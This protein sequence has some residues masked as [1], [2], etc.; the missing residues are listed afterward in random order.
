MLHSTLSRIRLSPSKSETQTSFFTNHEAEADVSIIHAPV[1]SDFIVYLTRRTK[2]YQ[3][4]VTFLFLFLVA[5]EIIS[6]FIPSHTK[7][8]E[9]DSQTNKAIQLLGYILL[10]LSPRVNSPSFSP[11]ILTLF[12]LMVISLFLLLICYLLFQRN[13]S[14]PLVLCVTYRYLLIILVTL[15]FPLIIAFCSKHLGNAFIDAQFNY[16]GYSTIFII[17]FFVFSLI[18]MTASLIFFHYTISLSDS[19]FKIFKPIAI[20]RLY[21]LL[22]IKTLVI[23][24]AHSTEIWISLPP[25]LVFIIS[26]INFLCEATQSNW[27]IQSQQ[28]RILTALFSSVLTSAFIFIDTLLLDEDKLHPK[29]IL[30]TSILFLIFSKFAI[31]KI[32]KIDVIK[33]MKRLDS[34]TY[35]DN[36]KHSISVFKDICIG[37]K[38]GHLNVI[39]T[40]HAEEIFERFHNVDLYFLFTR[41]IFTHPKSQISLR[42]IAD[43]IEPGPRFNPILNHI[44]HLILREIGPDNQELHDIFSN[45]IISLHRK[46]K[47]LIVSVR[48]VYD[49]ILNKL[50]RNLPKATGTFQYRYHK[51]TKHLLKFVQ[52]YPGSPDAEYFIKLFTTLFP[53][54]NEAHEIE[55]WQNY[56]PNYIH[57]DITLFPSHLPILLQNKCDFKNYNRVYSN[58][59]KIIPENLFSFETFYKKRMKQIGYMKGP[60]QYIIHKP[61]ILFPMIFIILYPLTFMIISYYDCNNFLDRSLHI[62]HGFSI[63]WRVY[64]MNNALY[65]ALFFKNETNFWHLFG[66]MDNYM[67]LKLKEISNLQTD[68]LRYAKGIGSYIHINLDIFTTFD[69]I[70]RMHGDNHFNTTYYQKLMHISFI[71]GDFL[72]YDYIYLHYDPDVIYGMNILS[73]ILNSS[74]LICNA[75]SD[76]LKSI[77]VNGKGLLVYNNSPYYFLISEIILLVIIFFVILISLKN[78]NSKLDLFL[79][80]LRE[81]SKAAVSKVLNDYNRCLTLVSTKKRTRRKHLKIRRQFNFL[82]HFALPS[83]IILLILIILI[84]MHSVLVMC[85]QTQTNNAVEAYTT[86]TE[87]YDDLSIVVISLTIL[88]FYPNVTEHQWD[89]TTNKIKRICQEY[90][91]VD[92]FF[93]KPTQLYCPICSLTNILLDSKV[94]PNK[95]YYSMIYE[96]LAMAEHT[97]ADSPESQSEELILNMILTYYGDIDY[98]MMNLFDTVL[99]TLQH[100]ANKTKS[101]ELT[102]LIIYAFF[103]IVMFSIMEIVIY[104]ADYPFHNV[105]MLLGRLPENSLAKDSVKILSNH[106]WDFESKMFEFDPLYYEH[107]LKTLPDPIIVINRLM[108]IIKYNIAAKQIINMDEELPKDDQK[109]TKLFECMAI[110]LY[111]MSEDNI[112]DESKHA[113]FCDI[114]EDYMYDDNCTT[115]NK[116]VGSLK[117][118]RKLYFDLIIQ[119]IDDA[120]LSS[121]LNQK[122]S[123]HFALI[124]KDIG[125]EIRQQKMLEQEAEK[126]LQIVN[127]IL[128]T[129][130]AHRLITQQAS[131]SF[132]IEKVAISF[133]DIVSFTP[134][135][136]SQTPETVVNTLNHMFKRFDKICAKNV[137][138]TKIKCIGDCYMTAAGVFSSVYNPDYAAQQMIEF[139]LD[140]IDA[141]DIIN[142]QVNSSLK[143]RIGVAYGGPISAGVMGMHKPVFDIWGEIVNIAN[144]MESSGKAM[145]AHLTSNLYYIAQKVPNITIEEG[146]DGTYFVSRE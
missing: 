38:Y 135:C 126:H 112:I 60:F 70:F 131:I 48:V 103:V 17:L 73:D 80:T 25:L 121:S 78:A 132:T 85:S 108:N 128:P 37:L 39:K 43:R 142:Q 31:Q 62:I 120:D 50:T 95:T 74:A 86:L 105:V 1:Y 96:W 83:S 52:K 87:V 68:L 109:K 89:K 46:F 77:D 117:S 8:W 82:L 6:G 58:V 115:V 42:D 138:V 146:D 107:I 91:K 27:A 88:K 13:R 4:F 51:T 113:S 35:P 104:L 7:F 110:D 23:A 145:H 81:T 130:I 20:V 101:Y 125:E 36:I 133:C 124:F 24:I 140:L 28:I 64:Q 137:E 59:R 106:S 26:L 143:V 72:T 55:F 98:V 119:P 45:E 75:L 71:S 111:E 66:S 11:I 49:M 123:G 122:D 21:F 67:M 15:L 10:V 90:E 16:N 22:G 29:H 134:W 97:L 100:N 129:Q 33:T 76:G 5:Q 19:L 116:K 94:T 63:K 41:L 34:L 2:I 141:I 114:V 127:Q 14:I 79:V 118:P 92:W 3:P 30:W 53:N 12:L 99:E 32:A 144:A 40:A 136:G 9:R 57:Q 44:H 69:K 61:F 139:C 18:M 47:N 102:I 84:C 56:N 93:S 54:S 65:P